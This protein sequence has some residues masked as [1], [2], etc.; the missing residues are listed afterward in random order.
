MSSVSKQSTR[1]RVLLDSVLISNNNIFI[2]A[3]VFEVK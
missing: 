2:D 1:M 3:E